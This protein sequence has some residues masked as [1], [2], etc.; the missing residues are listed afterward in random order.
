MGCLFCKSPPPRPRQ[1]ARPGLLTALFLAEKYDAVYAYR[2]SNY[3]LSNDDDLVCLLAVVIAKG[4]L[5]ACDEILRILLKT[6]RIPENLVQRKI[7]QRLK[8]IPRPL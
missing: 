5:Q 7:A 6:R 8:L 2:E 3:Y 4:E 1:I